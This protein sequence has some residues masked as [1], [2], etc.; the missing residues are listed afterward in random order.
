MSLSETNLCGRLL[1]EHYGDVLEKIGLHLAKKGPSPV[2]IIAKDTS[3]KVE[4]VTSA[5]YFDLM[6]WLSK[7]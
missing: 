6:V 1:K 2:G 4:Q 3:L 5:H 7:L